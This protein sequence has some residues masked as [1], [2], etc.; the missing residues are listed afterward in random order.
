MVRL[1]DFAG[2]W[3]PSGTPSRRLGETS[4][5]TQMAARISVSGR[6]MPCSQLETRL[7]LTPIRAAS[8]FWLKW[9]SSRYFRIRLPIS[10]FTLSPLFP[11][12][13]GKNGK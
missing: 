12:Y 6:L 4:G 13:T 8:C 10:Y 11:Y 5:A 2:G 9:L 1:F 7:L 3:L